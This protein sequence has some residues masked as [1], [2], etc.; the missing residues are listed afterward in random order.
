MA[1]RDESLELLLELLNELK[2]RDI[3]E[4]TG[5]TPPENGHHGLPRLPV[6]LAMQRWEYERD[7]SY[8]I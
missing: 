3:H 4:Q 6:G 2:P 7:G 1:S 5:T 8:K